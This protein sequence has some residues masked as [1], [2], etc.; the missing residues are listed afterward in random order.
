[1]QMSV[2]VPK[3]RPKAEFCPLEKVSEGFTIEQNV[4]NKLHFHSLR[5]PLRKIQLFGSLIR[6]RESQ[7][8]SDSGRESLSR[9]LEETDKLWPAINKLSVLSGLADTNEKLH[10]R[11]LSL[12]ALEALNDL[13]DQNTSY[14]IRMNLAGLG[15]AKVKPLQLRILFAQLIENAANFAHPDR[16]PELIMYSRIVRRGPEKK[17]YLHLKITDNGTG[18]ENHYRYSIF[19]LFSS[20]HFEDNKT[21][22][23]I[24]L[25]ICRKVVENHGGTVSA[26]GIP[27]EGTV[28]DIRIPQPDLLW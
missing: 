2:K 4:K 24:G 25:A 22:A 1:M 6:E 26:T 20:L 7:S 13:K 10:Q 21:H 9:L 5:N 18:F 14:D 3:R 15:V 28:I 23:G 12:I 17:K 27:G 11:E 16:A 8:L 19:D